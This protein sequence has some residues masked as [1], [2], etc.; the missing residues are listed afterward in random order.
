M[1]TARLARVAD[2]DGMSEVIIFYMENADADYPAGPLQGADAD[3]DLGLDAFGR[4][5][6]LDLLKSAVHLIT[7]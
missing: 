6:M 1:R 2:P 3:G 7:G 5:V 4:R